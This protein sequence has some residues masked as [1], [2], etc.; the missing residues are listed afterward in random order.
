LPPL[1]YVAFY[2]TV[3]RKPDIFRENRHSAPSYSGSFGLSA[4]SG[5]KVA[6]INGIEDEMIKKAIGQPRSSVHE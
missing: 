5:K 4:T 1:P 6:V 2:V 3:L